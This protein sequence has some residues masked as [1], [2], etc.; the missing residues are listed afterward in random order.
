MAIQEKPSV[1]YVS[2]QLRQGYNESPFARTTFSWL[3]QRLVLNLEEKQQN[4][5]QESTL[6]LTRMYH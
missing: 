6:K 2:L 1:N 4:K 5:I 3:Y